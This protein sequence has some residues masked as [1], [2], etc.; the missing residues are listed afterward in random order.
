MQKLI[1]SDPNNC[2][3]WTTPLIQGFKQVLENGT[4]YIGEKKIKIIFL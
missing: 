1:N 2:K 3:Y 4:F